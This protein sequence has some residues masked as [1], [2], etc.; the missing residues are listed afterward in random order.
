MINICV[1]GEQLAKEENDGGPRGGKA[2]K[3]IRKHVR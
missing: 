1:K 3:T 2:V